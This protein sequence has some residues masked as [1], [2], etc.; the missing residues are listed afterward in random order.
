MEALKNAEALP[1]YPS[2]S[3]NVLDGKYAVR[4]TESGHVESHGS[5]IESNTWFK[6]PPLDV[7][8]IQRLHSIQLITESHDQGYC[9]DR[10]NGNWTWFE[11]S[12]LENANATE[13]R[14]KDDV[15]LTWESHKNQLESKDFVQLEGTLFPEDH[16]IFRLLEDQNVIAVR[17]CSRFSGWELI[18][19][20]GYLVVEFG[21]PVEREPL[22]FG[23]IAAK[24]LYTL[25][26]FNDVNELSFPDLEEFPSLPATTFRADRMGTED[27]NER[28]LRVLSLDGG[29]VRGLASLLVLKAIMDRACP[30][31]KPCE[32]FDMIG[33]TSTGGLIAIM[34]GRLEMSVDECIKEYNA[35]M[36]DVFPPPQKWTWN[37]WTWDT[38]GMWMSILS[39]GEKWK[40]E[41]LEKVIK[42]LVK[43]VLNQDPE[44]VLLQDPKNPNP[45]CKVFVTA[46]RAEGA[47]NSEPVLL[48]SYKIKHAMPDLPKVKL[49]QAAR[50][51][52]AAPGYF[53]SI[54]I[55]GM[56]FIDG[57]VQANNPLGWLWNEVLQVFTAVRTTDCF[58][59]IGTGVSLSKQS[60]SPFGLVG[61]LTNTNIVNI[62][63]REL[64]NAFAPRG[65]TKKYW[66][67][68]FG[69]GLPD[70]VEEDGVM[71]WVYLAKIEATEGEMD[72]ITITELLKKK[73]DEYIQEPGF[74]KQL[75]DC[76]VAL[77]RS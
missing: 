52:S 17:V 8:T 56:S 66:R 18:A 55:D 60:V 46:S 11:I 21:P 23:T 2:S 37:P 32:V 54:E 68:D 34:L 1:I 15:Q 64:I 76:T 65:V 3:A 40:S 24:V 57:G 63:F 43:R 4:S 72:D 33:G 12:I 77:R 49:W 73:V 41:D 36:G 59:S 50:A 9:D 70:W 71:K 20:Q 42:G 62:L 58:L 26:A 47:N 44:E 67:F 48:R 5:E 25:E 19:K 13:P 16:D 69:D 31:K 35:L 7:K 38:N 45:S 61:I 22:R 74:Q 10:A 51:T 39:K 29:G 14:V 53:N 28:P 30:G 27:A 6:T 75:A